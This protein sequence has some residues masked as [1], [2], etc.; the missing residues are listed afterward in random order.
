LG[1]DNSVF[2]LRTIERTGCRNGVDEDF[3]EGDKR[4]FLPEN[5][6]IP[7]DYRSPLAKARRAKPAIRPGK[8][9]IL[10]FDTGICHT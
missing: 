5:K 4:N 2:A 6:A 10:L 9:W 8:I 7:D 3:H 1:G